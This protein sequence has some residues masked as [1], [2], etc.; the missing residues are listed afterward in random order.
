[1]RIHLEF[2]DTNELDEFVAHYNQNRGTVASVVRTPVPKDTVKE[3]PKE[4]P[5]PKAP[6]APKAD[7]KPKAPAAPKEEPKDEL[8]FADDIAPKILAI[9]NGKSREAAVAL[10]AKFGV[11]KGPQLKPEQF[12][13]FAEAADAVLAED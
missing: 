1:M 7:A 3:E 11:T 8:S 2:N 4:E 5:K 13:E 9:A 10:L 12:A 6:A